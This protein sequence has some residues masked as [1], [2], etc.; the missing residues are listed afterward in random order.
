MSSHPVN[1][2]WSPGM[3]ASVPHPCQNERKAAVTSGHPRTL[4]TASELG[5]CRLTLACNDLLS[6]RS[7]LSEWENLSRSVTQGLRCLDGLQ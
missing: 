6:G 4:R 2:T 1:P 7:A 3:H 5:A